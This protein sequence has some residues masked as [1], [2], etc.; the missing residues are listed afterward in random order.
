MKIKALIL[1]VLLVLIA[2]AQAYELFV[3]VSDKPIDLIFIG[4]CSLR[5]YR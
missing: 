2:K 1:V 4:N 5:N 3:Q